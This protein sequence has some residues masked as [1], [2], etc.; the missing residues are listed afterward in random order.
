MPRSLYRRIT[1]DKESRPEGDVDG[2]G[3]IERD[4]VEHPE[5]PFGGGE[6]AS[7]SL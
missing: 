7:V 2:Q 6:V 4:E 5:V 1:V 3:E